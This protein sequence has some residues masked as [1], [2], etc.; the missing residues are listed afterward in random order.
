MVG[1][2][3]EVE[4]GLVD[5]EL[6]VEAGLVVGVGVC[7]LGV[8]ARDVAGRERGGEAA[9]EVVVWGEGTA[10]ATVWSGETVAEEAAGPTQ[11][12]AMAR[13]GGGLVDEGAPG[14][15]RSS[16]EGSWGVREKGK[17]NSSKVTCRDT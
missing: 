1:L 8:E 12:G 5:G 3:E 10:G 17:T 9:G 13:D 7:E 4:A 14:W 15:K 11:D 6:L 2:P 16:D